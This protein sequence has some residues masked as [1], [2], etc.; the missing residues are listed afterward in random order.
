M[1]KA[2]V[3]GIN[4]TNTLGLIRSLGEAGYPVIVL[5]EP[6][7]LKFCFLRFSKYISTLHHLKDRAEGVR[8]LKEAFVNETDKPIV[9]CGS[10][11]SMSL[12][13]AHY[14]ELKEFVE[15]FNARGEQGRINHFMD[16]ANTFELAEKAGLTLIKT[17]RMRKGDTV[18]ADMVYPCLIKG[19]NSTMSS[20]KDMFIC[21]SRS[22]L[23]SHLREGVSYLVQQF[24]EK[25]YEIDVNGISINH[26][27]DVF[28]PG[29]VRKIREE[30][31]RQSDFIVLEKIPNGLDLEAIRRFVAEIGYEGLFSIEFMKKGEK[32]YFLEINLRNDGV[33]YLYTDAGVNMPKLWAECKG[34][35]LTGF[36]DVRFDLKLPRYLMQES[37]LANVRAGKVGIAV[38]LRDYWRAQSHF[39]FNWRDPLP[40]LYTVYVHFRQAGKKLWRKIS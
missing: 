18:S 23:E 39:V 19:N 21:R 10:D 36:S 14:D 5:L 28:I 8:V 27:G 26:G 33:N 11:S 17:W 38:W 20:K 40:F 9:F 6:C 3:Y 37:D 35:I 7:D 31:G 32:F 4:H 22:E 34:G 16:K 2:V 24:I 12:V 25:E 13:D 29:V 1:R 30:Y 15:V